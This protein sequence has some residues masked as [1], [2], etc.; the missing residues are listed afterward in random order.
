MAT[1]HEFYNTGADDYYLAGGNTWLFMEFTAESSYTISSVKI[2][3]EDY[4]PI[5]PTGTLTVSI[6][7]LTTDT[8][9]PTGGDLAS[10]TLDATSITDTSTWFEIT[11]GTPLAL[12]NGT[13]YAIVIGGC[14]GATQWACDAGGGYS[15]GSLGRSTD[16]KASWINWFEPDFLFENWEASEAIPSRVPRYGF[17]HYNNPAIA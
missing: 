6:T 5:P 4:D 2:P 9:I 12:T 17:I 1:L 13:H 10:G 11:F 14:G 3:L 8:H 16:N 7:A 15:G